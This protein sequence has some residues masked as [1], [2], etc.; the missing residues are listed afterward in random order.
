MNRFWISLKVS[1][2]EI[3]M[4][5]FVR[6]IFSSIWIAL[7]KELH[8]VPE[9]IEKII[10]KKESDKVSAFVNNS[11]VVLGDYVLLIINNHLDALLN[12]LNDIP[13]T[14]DPII[15]EIEKLKD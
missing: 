8:G 10:L 7:I 15:M 9:N 1:N 3:F 2:E 5:E 14:R 6:S 4:K 13:K 11:E 12:S